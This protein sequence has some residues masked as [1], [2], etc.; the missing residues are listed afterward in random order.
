MAVEAHDARLP[1]VTAAG[2]TIR[3]LVTGLGITEGVVWHPRDQY[4][5]FSDLSASVVYR[6]TQR[7]GA[8]VLRK[9]SNITNGNFVDRQG[10]VISCEHATSCVSRMEEG[11]RHV[12]VLA[13]HYRGQEFNSPNDLVCDSRDRI[14]FSDPLYGRTNPRVAVLREPQLAFQGVF[15]LEPDGAVTLIADDFAEPNGLCL[16]PGEALLY[17]ADTKR[18]HI[19]RFEVRPDGQVSGGDVFATV[20]GEGVGKPDG[21]KVDVAGRVYCT[22][23]GG[24]HVFSSAGELL[25]VIATPVKT[26]NFCFGGADGRTLYLAMDQMIGSLAMEVAGVPAPSL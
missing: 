14:W 13:S 18:E 8:T 4:L 3:P 15:R 22:G 9:P 2:A 7:E 10:R 17:V 21:L 11:G 20:A 23:P 12:R 6:W 5:V 25:G 26:R 19:R 1:G 16:A 24:I